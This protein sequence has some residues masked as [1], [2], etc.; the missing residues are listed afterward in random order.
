MTVIDI[1]DY[2]LATTREVKR[3]RVLRETRYDRL[4]N[5]ISHREWTEGN[6]PTEAEL[7]D[8]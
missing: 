7:E 1:N 5:T 4:G 8:K 3:G 2:F 6:A